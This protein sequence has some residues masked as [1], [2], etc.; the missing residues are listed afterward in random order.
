MKRL[1][2]YAL[3]L[4]ALV[5][6]LPNVDA[7]TEPTSP[8]PASPEAHSADLPTEPV[9]P[10][11]PAQPTAPTRAPERALRAEPTAK[12]IP[13]LPRRASES[14]PTWPVPHQPH[15][16]PGPAAQQ[17]MIQATVLEINWEKLDETGI[18]LVEFLGEL[19]SR[20]TPA[21]STVDGNTERPPFLAVKV[22]QGVPDGISRTLVAAR[23][24]KIVSSPRVITLTG[25]EATVQ[26]GGAIP[27]LA[28]ENI[29][30][31]V[32][33]DVEIEFG[34]VGAQLKLTPHLQRDNTIQLD[35]DVTRSEL[36]DAR[37]L[38]ES[39]RK[40]PRI[41]QHQHRLR[42]TVAAN[43]AII[44]S[45]TGPAATKTITSRTGDK[46][47]RE[48]LSADDGMMVILTPH[49]IAPAQV[50]QAERTADLAVLP[51]VR[52]SNHTAPAPPMLP[53]GHVDNK[54]PIAA[55]AQ[56]T[57]VAKPP[58]AME[59]MKA[60]GD[61]RSDVSELR[62]EVR[63]LRHDVRR[64]LE[65]LGAEDQATH[66]ARQRSSNNETTKKTDTRKENVTGQTIDVANVLDQRL[67]IDFENT[68]LDRALSDLSATV[69]VEL[70]LVDKTPFPDGTSA[71]SPISIHLVDVPLRTALEQILD[72]F[73]LRITIDGE[74][75]L[76]TADP[77]DA[78]CTVKAYPVGD[79]LASPPFQ[80]Q[81][82]SELEE[83]T[84][85]VSGSFEA[86]KTHLRSEVSPTS[87]Q[88]HDGEGQ[89]ESYA[90]NLSLVVSAGPE[91][92]QQLA[93][94][95]GRLRAE[96]LSRV[97]VEFQL[98]ELGEEDLR[99]A[100]WLRRTKMPLVVDRDGR[101]K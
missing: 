87:W 77:H 28:R 40:I 97:M 82:V 15:Q 30:N 32:K 10:P 44:L 75:I 4:T 38:P 34:H 58:R 66:R 52:S 67:S 43:E 60:T 31:G 47:Q 59:A 39:E 65:L 1:Y 56:P 16:L 63:A 21:R 101:P 53:F 19:N 80:R 64:L 41:R 9:Q 37:H 69:G 14:K 73:D 89:M 91:V 76:L 11:Q 20:D 62:R 81:S 42:A 48:Q 55:P 7:Q 83:P 33:Q 23:A 61:L 99:R 94:E 2:F 51:P 95:L 71:K 27:F 84:F 74:R 13:R 79:L 22:P 45:E 18:D 50:A 25:Q 8:P 85:D 96:H 93:A 26:I 49:V 57:Q 100:T 36:L 5:I 86:L 17:V 88:T 6:G 29:E 70:K 90:A 35:I 98:V 24:V 12:A 46:R 54:P 78:Q 3:T 72:P 92:H 68:P